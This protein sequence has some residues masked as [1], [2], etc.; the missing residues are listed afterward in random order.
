[1]GGRDEGRVLA[2]RPSSEAALP[3]WRGAAGVGQKVPSVA[4][5][6]LPLTACIGVQG[7]A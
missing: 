6:P 4:L 7:A 2:G 5:L 1:M 3:T